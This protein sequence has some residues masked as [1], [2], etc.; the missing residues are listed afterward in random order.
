[1]PTS[2]WSLPASKAYPRLNFITQLFFLFK[3]LITR[4]WFCSQQEQRYHYSPPAFYSTVGHYYLHTEMK[5]QHVRLWESKQKL[6]SHFWEEKAKASLE[7]PAIHRDCA[8]LLYRAHREKIIPRRN[9]FSVQLFPCSNTC[10]HIL[11]I[12][13]LDGL[14]MQHCLLQI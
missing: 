13:H 1:M 9:P 6:S 3:P 14:S 8:P 12:L 4:R 2:S 10:F 11:I 5:G 7:Y